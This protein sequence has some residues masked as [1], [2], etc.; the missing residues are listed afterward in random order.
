MTVNKNQ[1]IYWCY[2]ISAQEVKQR[3]IKT[4]V[5]TQSKMQMKGWSIWVIR[6][7]YLDATSAWLLSQKYFLLSEHIYHRPNFEGD[8]ETLPLLGGNLW[9]MID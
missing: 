7:H 6:F 5:Y 1:M 3:I 9:Y 2:L 8:T 4:N